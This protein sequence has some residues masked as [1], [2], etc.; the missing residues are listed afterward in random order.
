MVC[1]DVYFQNTLCKFDFEIQV[2]KYLKIT[3][4]IIQTK[5]LIVQA[6]KDA[7]SKKPRTLS[8]I[9]NLQLRSADTTARTSIILYLW[10]MYCRIYLAKD[11][12]VSN[13]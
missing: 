3:D 7:L 2:I 1:A 13:T 10:K 6:S 5:V 8:T 4:Y 12:M 11:E 9:S